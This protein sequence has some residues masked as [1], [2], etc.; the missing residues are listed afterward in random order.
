MCSITD[1]FPRLIEVCS[2]GKDGG[3]P[4]YRQEFTANGMF[5]INSQKIE[6]AHSIGLNVLDYDP[7]TG[8]HNFEVVNIDRRIRVVAG[9]EIIQVKHRFFFYKSKFSKLMRIKIIKIIYLGIKMSVVW[10]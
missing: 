1:N 7:A 3:S 5:V 2:D 10:K 6:M 8:N 4:L 9:G